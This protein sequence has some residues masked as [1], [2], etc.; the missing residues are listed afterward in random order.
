LNWTHPGA[1]PRAMALVDRA[2]PANSHILKRG[3]AG[4]PGDEVPRRFLEVLSDATRPAFTNGSGRFELAQEIASKQN[5]LTARVFVNRIWMHHFG[6]GF[7]PTPG[8]FGVR[9]EQPVH[10]ALLDYLAAS[11]MENGWSVK[12][13]HR[14]IVLSA[15]YQQGS[16]VGPDLLGTDPENR[17]L[18]RF[19]R[20]RL[21]FE[22]LR[23]TLLFAAGTLDLRL[24]GLPVDLESEPFPVRR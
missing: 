7:V 11:F 1:P 3:S 13:L 17:L 2:N 12:Q 19:S 14:L 23:D 9:T 22:A 6:E 16:N 5:P 10:H 21:D 8:D 24:G 18:S 15:T 20:Q 4:S